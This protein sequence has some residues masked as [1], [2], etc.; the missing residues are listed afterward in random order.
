MIITAIYVMRIYTVYF[1]HKTLQRLLVLSLVASHITM[2]V[3]TMVCIARTTRTWS[4]YYYLLVH[5]AG[6]C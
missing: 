2:I 6:Q 3:L 1:N 5:V 4:D